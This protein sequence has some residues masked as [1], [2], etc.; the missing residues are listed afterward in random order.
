MANYIL[1]LFF[2]ILEE[3]EGFVGLFDALAD[4]SRK[5]LKIVVNI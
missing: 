4:N 3:D 1:G 5:T 2:D